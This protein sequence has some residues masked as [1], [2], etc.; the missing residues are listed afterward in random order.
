MVHM[1]GN[2]LLDDPLNWLKSVVNNYSKL[3]GV[4]M[5]RQNVYEKSLATIFCNAKTILY[6]RFY[7]LYLFNNALFL[8]SFHTTMDK[9]I[10]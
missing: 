6:L 7:P 10:H 8:C 2:V 4:C 5:P 1:H 3:R 9:N